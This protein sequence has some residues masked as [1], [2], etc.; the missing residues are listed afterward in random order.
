MILRTWPYLPSFLC[1]V[2]DC[3]SLEED[4]SLALALVPS[5]SNGGAEGG[6]ADFLSSV[7]CRLDLLEPTH[8]GLHRFVPRHSDEVEVEIGDP[9]SQV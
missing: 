3:S 9:V 4:D 6:H 5:S 8:R 1:T 7:G 2:L